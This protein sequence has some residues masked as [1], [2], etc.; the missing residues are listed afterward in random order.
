MHRFFIFFFVVSGELKGLRAANE[1]FKPIGSDSCSKGKPR[2]L[3]D[4][5]V[6]WVEETST[7]G[8]PVL[9]NIKTRQAVPMPMGGGNSTDPSV[10]AALLG[11]PHTAAVPPP[12]NKDA[13]IIISEQ[14]DATPGSFQVQEGV[15]GRRPAGPLPRCFFNRSGFSCCNHLL[16]DSVEGLM[17][18]MQREPGYSTCN[19]HR[20]TQRI[21]SML[22]STT[23]WE[24]Q[25]FEILVSLGDFGQTVHFQ[26]DL[27][28]KLEIDG[29]FFLV[30][31]TPKFDSPGVFMTKMRM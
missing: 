31:G 4:V 15:N 22:R 2:S 5:E 25:D 6:L 13:M 30:Y 27:A 21:S 12:V 16:N 23:G 18:R 24:Q 29:K 11:A 7:E 14:S 19:T 10:I 20:I 8:F 17:E 9:R 3:K 26:G 1:C 28:C